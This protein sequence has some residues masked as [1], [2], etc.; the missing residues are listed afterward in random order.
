VPRHRTQQAPIARLHRR[1]GPP[2]HVRQDRRGPEYPVIG[3]LDRGPERRG[4]RQAAA[5]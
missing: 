1:P 4:R 5:E 2:G 3:R